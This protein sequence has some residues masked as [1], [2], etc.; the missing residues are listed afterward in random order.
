MGRPR[1]SWG[2]QPSHTRFVGD[3]GALPLPLAQILDQPRAETESRS[4]VPLTSHL[5]QA[6][7]R[8]ACVWMQ[9]QGQRPAQRAGQGQP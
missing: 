5:K 3:G 4:A 8:A 7:R 6:T 1:G 9:A 2:L